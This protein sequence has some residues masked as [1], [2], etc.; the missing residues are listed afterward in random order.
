MLQNVHNVSYLAKCS[1]ILAQARVL[2]TSAIA[3]P[4]NA[5]ITHISLEVEEA[6]EAVLCDVKIGDTL[7]GND[8]D[9]SQKGVHLLNFVGKTSST[10]TLNVEL[11][12]KSA[13]G[14]IHLR[15]VY[16]LPSQIKVEY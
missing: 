4:A 5:E 3:L 16:F 15:C 11:S 14:M 2:L 8:I 6:G 10:T 9:L 13:S 1:L 12:E 7:I